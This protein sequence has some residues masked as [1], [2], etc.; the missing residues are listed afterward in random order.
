[1]KTIK[2]LF[3]EDHEMVRKSIIQS[4]LI[5]KLF[6]AKIDEAVN[7]IE[8]IEKATK[9]NYDVII[10]DI[11]LPLKDGLFVTKLLKSK[12]DNVRILA[13]TLHNEYFIIK[14]MIEAGVLGY[15]LKNSG[16]G[17]LITAILKVAEFEKYY[18]NDVAQILLNKSRKTTRNGNNS[19]TCQNSVLNADITPRE[20]EI[21]SLISMEFTNKEIGERLTI[22]ERTVSNHRNNLILKLQ[23]K[24]SIGLATYAVKNGL[25]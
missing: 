3:A 16:I 5:Q 19:L 8:A 10:L 9:N 6:V 7:G 25:I 24:N 20:L 17:E 18:C 13:L 21:L 12:N 4:L 23:V 11:N 22:S 2:I 1:M 14:Q 15:V